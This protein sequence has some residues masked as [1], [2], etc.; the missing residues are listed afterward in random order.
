[1]FTVRP[2]ENRTLSWWN[3]ERED[4]DLEPPYQRSSGIWTS[5]DQA[6]LIDSILN[7]FDIPKIYIADFTYVDTTLNE[8]HKKYAVIDGKQRLESIFKFFDGELILSDTFEYYADIS[9][10]LAGLGYTDL[11][12]RYPR[13]ASVFENFN[14]ATMSVITDDEGKIN[15]LFV[16]LNRS[17]PLTGAE[18]R[19]AMKGE[20]PILI[21]N[22]AKHPFF[23]SKIKFGTKRS[24]DQNA[25]AKLLLTEF[26]GKFVETKKKQ[27][28]QLVEEGVLSESSTFDRAVRRVKNELN[29]MVDVFVDKDPLLGSQGPVVL[30]YWLVR[31]CKDNE[32]D[33]V[34]EFLVKFNQERTNNRKSRQNG[35][36]PRDEELL[37]YDVLHRSINNVGSQIE[38][39]NILLR[40]FKKFQSNDSNIN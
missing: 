7:G 18:L 34:R 19:N 11:K 23:Q 27:L 31:N 4:I 21:R 29:K 20:V 39:Y 2:F 9:L 28:D 25:A 8:R 5:E 24:Q 40:R 36:R 1:M 33:K 12:K 15:E 32:L 3:G 26:R 10:N 22:L 30:Y 35:E 38:C 37:R 16:R 13:V 17:R 6:F 14:L